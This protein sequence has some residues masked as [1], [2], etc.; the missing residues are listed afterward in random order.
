MR[1]R[2]GTERELNILL[3][4]VVGSTAYGLATAGSDV[5]RLGMFAVPT[6]SLLGLRP[7]EESHVTTGPD[8]TLHEAGKWCRL[9]LAGNPTVT[10][11]VWLPDDLHEIRTELGDEL[12]GI[13]TAFLSGG[14]VRDAYLGYATQQFRKLENRGDGAFSADTAKRTAKH[15]RHLARLVHQGRELYAT[16][17]L[18]I[19]LEDPQ[20]YLDFGERVAGGDLAM[21]RALLAEAEADFARIRTP[22]PGDPDADTVERWLLRVRAE[23]Y[24]PEPHPAGEVFLVDLDGTVAL[25]DE[26]RPDVRR[27]YD[28]HRVGEDLPNRPVVGVVHALVRSGHRIIYLSGRSES[29]RAATSVWIAEHVGVPGEALLMRASDD[30]RPDSVIKRELYERYVAPRYTVTAVLDDRNT[31]VRMWR[32][33]GLTVLQVADGDF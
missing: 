29:A 11:L 16:G 9:A 24:A 20:W 19:R 33:L 3:S 23:H 2:V 32:D 4:G 14:R 28:W 27:F 5:D 21:A 6:E 18:R 15:A 26:T 17:R 25:R 22:L 7:P 10:E 12:I 30:S 13:R 1:Q 31:V 8:Q